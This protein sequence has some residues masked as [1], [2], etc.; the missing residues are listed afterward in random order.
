MTPQA[1]DFGDPAIRN[2][3]Q[4]RMLVICRSDGELY[5]RGG[6]PSVVLR[7]GKCERCGHWYATEAHHRWLRSQQGPDCASNLA[8]L[9]RDCHNWCHAN[10]T[11]ARKGGWMLIAGDKPAETP[12]TLAS[13]LRALLR[14]DGTYEYVGQAAASVSVDLR[15]LVEETRRAREIGSGALAG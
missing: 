10:P 8:A 6:S 7:P 13:G 1:P 4:L 15:A 11:E 14:D 12:V 3:E 2:Y 9:C 5:W